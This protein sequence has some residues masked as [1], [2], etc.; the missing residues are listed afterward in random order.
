MTEELTDKE[1]EVLEQLQIEIRTP[2]VSVE[3][4]TDEGE[5]G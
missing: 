2:V 5:N 1:R 3:D 4:T